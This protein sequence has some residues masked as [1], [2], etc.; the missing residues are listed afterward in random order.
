MIV[1]AIRKV[2]T[3]QDLTRAEAADAMEEIMAGRATAA[4]IA[5][6]ITA[7]KMKGERV[8]EVTGFAER[9]RA[10]ALPVCPKRTDL[11]DTCGT[12]GDG[13]GSFNIST[14]AAFVV[15]G[16]GLGVAK[17][18]NRAMSSTCGSADVLE[19]LGIRLQM[20]P[21]R[22]AQAIDEVGVGFLFA[23]FF[24]PAMKHAAPVRREIG[25]RTV[26]NILGPLTNP[27]GASAQLLGVFH[28][29]LTDIL[30]RALANLGARR[31]FVVHGH[32]ALD[33]IATT[34]PTLVS[35]LRDGEVRSYELD[36]RDYGFPIP[37]PSELKGAG[38]P[39]GNAELLQRVLEGEAGARRDIVVLNAAAALVAG[40][41]APDLRAG[42]AL[43][44][45][46][47]DSGAARERLEA[48]RRFSQANENHGECKR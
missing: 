5:A 19:A 33:E 34:G 27:A 13:S 18:G 23:Q 16:A 36:P 29:A 31:A 47:I 43:A 14:A 7:L 9:M 28:P 3:G 2:T 37:H 21:D 32:G 20:S 38:T 22:V 45:E 35:E 26:F 24:H 40:G 41:A 25:I 42:I 48:L 15:A 30:A 46:S 1:E 17:H 39:R 6:L 12:G 44:C 8:E 4:Q 10:H 11:V